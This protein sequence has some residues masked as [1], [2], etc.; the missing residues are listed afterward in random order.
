MSAAAEESACSFLSLAPITEGFL[1]DNESGLKL[2]KPP[3]RLYF[4]SH[5]PCLWRSYTCPNTEDTSPLWRCW[6]GTTIP[7]VL[8]HVEDADVKDV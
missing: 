8:K 5:Q 4:C 1:N 2:H 6:S 3:P 7:T